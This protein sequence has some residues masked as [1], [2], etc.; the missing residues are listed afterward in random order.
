MLAISLLKFIFK[1]FLTMIGG[2]IGGMILVK[3]KVG[4][5]GIIIA[6]K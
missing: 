1:T 3:G 4:E 5:I 2:R 6:I